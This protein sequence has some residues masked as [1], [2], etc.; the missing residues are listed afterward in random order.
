MAAPPADAAGLSAA[1]EPVV[2]V[3]GSADVGAW[4]TAGDSA[5]SDAGASADGLAPVGGIE[6]SVDGDASP[7]DSDAADGLCAW[8]PL[9]RA[10][11]RQASTA[12]VAMNGRLSICRPP[13]SPRGHGPSTVGG[14]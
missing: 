8:T 11:N 9:P 10:S 6:A 1:G 5:P 13:D 3:E 7:G 12:R 2:A 14:R 4:E